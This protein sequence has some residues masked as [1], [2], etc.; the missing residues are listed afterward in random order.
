MLGCHR[1]IWWPLWDPKGKPVG[2][3][4]WP[5]SYWITAAQLQPVLHIGFHIVIHF[6]QRF[7]WLKSEKWVTIEIQVWILWCSMT[8]KSLNPPLFLGAFSFA[9]QHWSHMD[10]EKFYFLSQNSENFCQWL[11]SPGW[12]LWPSEFSSWP[13]VASPLLLH[14]SL[15][16][17]GHHHPKAL[18]QC[19]INSWRLC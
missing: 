1:E 5:L 13:L 7:L 17:F 18:T 11:H 14:A 15:V 19:P 4:F 12:C 16:P 10:C 3:K 6:M 2:H 9:I 8:Q